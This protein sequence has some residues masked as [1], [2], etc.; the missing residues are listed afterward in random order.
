VPLERAG[1][2][3]ERHDRTEIEIVARPSLAAELRHAVAG[4]V[5]HRSQVRIG[6]PRQPDGAA[7]ALPCVAGRPGIVSRRAHGRHRKKSPGFLA[8]F[9]IER[10]HL[11]APPVVGAQSN[12]HQTARIQRR[13]GSHL[14][15]VPRIV[16]EVL[17]PD[18]RS[19]L[20]VERDDPRIRESDEH[21]A[22]ANRDAFSRRRSQAARRGT[23]S[24]PAAR[25]KP[26]DCRARF[27]VQRID[28]WRNR[29]EDHAVL[30][31]RHRARGSGLIE[32]F[33]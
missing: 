31:D 13:T 17:I 24:S 4:H 3:V 14:S 33:R 27:R 22:L 2:H 1:L 19:A 12:R 28:R 16:A 18:E 11:S 26:P 9:R 7:A 32:L 15:F 21:E 8:G 30:D 25:L 23:A 20:L 10:H 5:V 29:H 6:R